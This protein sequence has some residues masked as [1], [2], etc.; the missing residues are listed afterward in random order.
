MTKNFRWN[1]SACFWRGPT[2]GFHRYLWHCRNH[3]SCWSYEP[4]VL[5]LLGYCYQWMDAGDVYVGFFSLGRRDNLFEVCRR[6]RMLWVEGCSY[7]PSDNIYFKCVLISLSRS[8]L[9]LMQSVA[10]SFG[11]CCCQQMWSPCFLNDNYITSWKDVGEYMLWPV[12]GTKI[13]PLPKC[14]DTYSCWVFGETIAAFHPM[15][16]LI[17]SVAY[18]KLVKSFAGPQP[19]ANSINC[20]HHRNQKILLCRGIHNQENAGWLYSRVR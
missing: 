15:A 20:L 18:M 12:W 6:Q 3:W 1:F 14:A 2:F 17:H 16:S 4:R 13:V 5:R 8:G 10:K 11:T 19:R 9:I 7:L